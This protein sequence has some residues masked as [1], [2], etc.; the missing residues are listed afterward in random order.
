MQWQWFQKFSRCVH[1]ANS[2]LLDR[3]TCQDR[4]LAAVPVLMGF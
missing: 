3:I 2:A 4:A 1:K